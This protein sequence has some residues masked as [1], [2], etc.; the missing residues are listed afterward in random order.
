MNRKEEP[1]VDM[2]PEDIKAEIR[3]RGLTFRKLSHALP[4]S[5]CQRLL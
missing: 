4:V 3:K 2:H 1:S 5:P